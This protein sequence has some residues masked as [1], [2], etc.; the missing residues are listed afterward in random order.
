M[1]HRNLRI[2][3]QPMDTGV[4]KAGDCTIS[5]SRLYQRR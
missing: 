2:S 3:L 5:A 1:A 4:G